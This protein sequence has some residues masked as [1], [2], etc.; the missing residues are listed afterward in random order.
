MET[1]YRGDYMENRLY[2]MSNTHGGDYIKNELYK[3]R[4]I[5]KKNYIQRRQ[6]N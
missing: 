6:G 3:E 4:I 1:I 5:C 2:I